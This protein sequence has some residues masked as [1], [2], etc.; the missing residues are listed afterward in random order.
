MR[1]RAGGKAHGEARIIGD[2]DLAPEGAKAGAHIE[3]ERAGIVEGA[4][5]QPQA[6]DRC[7]PRAGDGVMH[8]EA[9]GAAPDELGREGETGELAVLR[10]AKIKLAEPHVVRAAG[11]RVDLDE[12]VV[13][14]GLER[15]V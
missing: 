11:K 10:Y 2:E 13:E 12:W 15:R 5:V 3:I 7:L 1:R 4:G 9:P 6:R 8:Q 14:D